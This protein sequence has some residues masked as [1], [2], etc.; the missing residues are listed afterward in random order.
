MRNSFNTLA[1]TLDRQSKFISRPHFLYLCK[2]W[3][4]DKIQCK[5]DDGMYSLFV[6]DGIED[7]EICDNL[8]SSDDHHLAEVCREMSSSN[9]ELNFRS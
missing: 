1:L 3:K 4:L 6:G 9:K 8:T 5:D 7:S 2:P